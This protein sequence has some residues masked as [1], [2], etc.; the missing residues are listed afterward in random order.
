MG[1]ASRRTRP[2]ANAFEPHLIKEWLKNPKDVPQHALLTKQTLM[3]LCR[4]YERNDA[5]IEQIGQDD[6]DGK[7]TCIGSPKC[8]KSNDVCYQICR[9]IYRDENFNQEK[10]RG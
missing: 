10:C 2:D 9:R 8:K 5:T 6:D 7:Y 3:G 4:K 1:P